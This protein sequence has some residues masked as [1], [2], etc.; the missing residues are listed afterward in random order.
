MNKKP[1]VF[2]IAGK[3]QWHGKR[4]MTQTE[5][6]SRAGITTVRIRH[7]ETCR[8]LPRS[9]ITLLAIAQALDTTID[10]LIAPH[11]IHNA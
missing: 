7:Y 5:L 6:A 3:R 2:H 11:I 10:E 4:P 9:I 1:F 8:K